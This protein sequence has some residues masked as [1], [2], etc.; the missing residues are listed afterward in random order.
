MWWFLPYINMNQP[1]VY[2]CPRILNPPPT[3]LTL[4]GVFLLLP[5]SDL[6]VFWLNNLDFCV[7]PFIS[8]SPAPNP[9]F[10]RSHFAPEQVSCE[11]PSPN[12]HKAALFMMCER[13]E[14]L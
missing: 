14:E 5:F 9:S 6:V 1:R 13:R 7:S 2:T 11:V 3:S 12:T 10:P 8:R 4:E